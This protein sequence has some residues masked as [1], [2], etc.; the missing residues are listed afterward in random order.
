MEDK[1]NTRSRRALVLIDF[2]NDFI[3]P[4]GRMPVAQT[5]VASVLSAARQ[6]ITLA[7]ATG[8]LVV[9][10]GNEFRHSDYLMNLLRR[11]ASMAGSPGAQWVR[12]LPLDGIPYFPKW[13]SSAFVNSDFDRW[14]HA[15]NVHTLRL[16]GLQAKACVTA[17]AKDAMKRG[18]SVEVLDDAIACVSD[19]S[20]ARA[21]ARL[22]RR[23]VRRVKGAMGLAALHRLFWYEWR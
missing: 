5:Q 17:T 1:A 8:D 23:G 18:Y 19:R 4:T 12:D 3:Q 20:R 15:E 21:L 6:A 16:A 11:S 7:R 14:L 10:I 13:A 9:A 22:E 2:Q